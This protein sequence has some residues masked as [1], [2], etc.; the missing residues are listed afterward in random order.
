MSP[1]PMMWTLWF[2]TW[3]GHQPMPV[4]CTILFWALALLPVMFVFL[5]L[6]TCPLPVMLYDWTEHLSIACD[7]F[8]LIW[9]HVHCLW[10][11]LIDLSTCPLPVMLFWLIWAHVHC[12]WCFFDWSE[13]M[14]SYGLVCCSCWE[15]AWGLLQLGRSTCSSSW[16]QG[17][18]LQKIWNKKWSFA[19]FL[20]WST[21]KSTSPPTCQCTSTRKW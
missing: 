18:L 19:S 5:Y 20:W 7:V 15:G 10:C 3:Y 1:L 12:L 6:N 16:F 11:F 14:F 13:N 21:W 17:K 9:A 4:I 2:W 8:G